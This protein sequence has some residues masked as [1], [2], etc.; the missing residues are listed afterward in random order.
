MLCPWT[1]GTGDAQLAR[2]ARNDNRRPRTRADEQFIMIKIVLGCMLLFIAISWLAGWGPSTKL[3]RTIDRQEAANAPT[4]FLRRCAAK[5]R[6]AKP[7]SIIAQVAGLIGT[8]HSNPVRST[9]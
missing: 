6:P 1:T 9:R 7:S 3:P 5:P 8:D 2:Q 4:N